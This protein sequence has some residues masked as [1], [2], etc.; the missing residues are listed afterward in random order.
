MK[1]NRKSVAIAAAVV[2]LAAGGLGVATAVGGDDESVT[3][4]DADKA[5]SAALQAV[6]GGTVTEVEHQDGDG[7]GVYEVEVERADGSQ[8][9][10]HLDGSFNPVGTAADDDTGSGSDDDGPGDDD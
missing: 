3:G 1:I 8:V 6:G 10:V 7:G 2:A 9:E 5:T 4:P